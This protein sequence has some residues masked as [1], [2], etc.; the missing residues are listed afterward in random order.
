MMRSTFYGFEIAR[1]GLFTNQLALDVTAHNIAN[2]NTPGYT[3][4]RL[5]LKSLPPAAGINGV[6]GAAVKGQVGAGVEVQELGQIRDS[7]LDMQ[8]RRENKYLGEWTV[9]YDGLAYIEGIFS[10]PSDSSLNAVLGEFF[11]S[12]QE[13]SKNPE[14]EEVRSLVRQNAIKVTETLHHYYSQLEQLQLEQNQ[15]IEITINEVNDYARQIRDLNEQIFR[16]E[17]GGDRANDLRDQRNLLVDKLSSIINVDVYETGGGRL[18]LDI[19]GMPLVDH[20]QVNLMEARIRTTAANSSDVGNLVDVYWAGSS[21]KVSITSGKLKGYLNVRDGIGPN[22]DGR[23]STMGIPY[24]MKKLNEFTDKFVT[25]FNAQHRQG[26]NIP[27]DSSPNP[28]TSV[29]NIDFFDPSKLTAREI[30]ISDDIKN[31]VYNIAASSQPVD[32]IT[33]PDKKGDN[34]NIIRL[35]ELRDVEF[36]GFGSFESFFRSVISELAVESSHSARMMETQEA[37][38]SHLD[39]QRKS[40]SGVSLDEEMTNMIRFQQSYAAAARIITA[41][42]ET[43]DIL[44]NRTGLV[45]R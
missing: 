43:L 45:G 16:F 3:R 44:I 39:N 20:T 17:A 33:D 41:I 42:D 18:R 21:V 23:N 34:N 11:N 27:N 35:V 6:F 28:G 26:W 25:E 22:T 29:N 32:D 24:Y 7:F 8:F 31:S 1:K 13:L 40:V 15:G 19:N 4:Q 36:N 14:S 12:L 9:Q 10:E 38:T 37:M 5:A 30:T 2:A